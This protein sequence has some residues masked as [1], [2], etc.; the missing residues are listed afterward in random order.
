[1]QSLSLAEKIIA[2]WRDEKI[3]CHGNDVDIA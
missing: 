1:M 3:G 2:T